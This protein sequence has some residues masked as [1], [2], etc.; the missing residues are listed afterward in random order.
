MKKGSKCSNPKTSTNFKKCL[1]L[2]IINIYNFVI[3]NRISSFAILCSYQDRE[4]QWE[5]SDWHSFKMSDTVAVC[6]IEETLLESL[7]QFRFSKSKKSC[8]IIMKVEGS[9]VISAGALS[10]LLSG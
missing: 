4:S 5:F 3:S 1:F 7:K 6:Q 9:I 2:N 10:S 8:A